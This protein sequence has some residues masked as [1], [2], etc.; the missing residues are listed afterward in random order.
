MTADTDIEK[1]EQLNL[2]RM[3]LKQ[4]DYD[5]TDIM[6]AW[7]ALGEL[8]ARLKEREGLSEMLKG[9]DGVVLKYQPQLSSAMDPATPVYVSYTVDEFIEAARPK[10]P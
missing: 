7:I 10:E 1:L 6:A 5:G 4:G 9:C 2:V 3:R 8:I